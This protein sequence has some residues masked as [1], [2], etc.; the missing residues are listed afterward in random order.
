M[1]NLGCESMEDYLDTVDVMAKHVEKLKA[2]KVENKGPDDEDT[3]INGV[4]IKGIDE[5]KNPHVVKSGSSSGTKR[6]CSVCKQGGHNKTTCPDNKKQKVSAVSGL[7]VEG[8]H[9]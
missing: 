7:G 5:V 3:N 1:F 2:K 4:D 9:A 6:K 8:G